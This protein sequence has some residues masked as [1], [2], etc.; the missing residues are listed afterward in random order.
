LAATHLQQR[1]GNRLQNGLMAVGNRCIAQSDEAGALAD[2]LRRLPGPPRPAAYVGPA[3]PGEARGN[4]KLV[5]A[6]RRRD[7][8]T[9]RKLWELSERLTG[10]TFEVPVAA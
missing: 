10:V 4:P 9:A 1:T 8:E 7:G 2:A 3:A 6:A 5:G